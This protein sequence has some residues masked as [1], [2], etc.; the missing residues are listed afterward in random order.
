MKAADMTLRTRRWSDP[1]QNSMAA[2]NRRIPALERQ[3]GVCASNQAASFTA[4][5]GSRAIEAAS[6]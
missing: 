3:W 6:A 2:P 5:A 1:L 4:K